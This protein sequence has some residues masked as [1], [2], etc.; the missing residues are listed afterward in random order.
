M[1]D[2]IE[3]LALSN[4]LILRLEQRPKHHLRHNNVHLRLDIKDSGSLCFGT[5]GDPNDK[6]EIDPSRNMSKYHELTTAS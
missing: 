4:N 3:D 2:C 6:Q 5:D 1:L